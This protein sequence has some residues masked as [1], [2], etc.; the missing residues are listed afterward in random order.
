MDVDENV[1]DLFQ[2]PEHDVFITPLAGNSKI[3]DISIPKF[4]D[5]KPGSIKYVSMICSG[6]T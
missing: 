1:E 4:S 5:L 2:H 3:E 6:S